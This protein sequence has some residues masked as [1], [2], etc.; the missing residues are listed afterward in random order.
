VR[1]LVLASG[2]N[3]LIFILA[4]RAYLSL[5]VRQYPQTKSIR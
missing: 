3:L 2:V 4:L 1:R 5:E